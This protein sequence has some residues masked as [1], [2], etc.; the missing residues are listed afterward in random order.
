[1]S[2]F[3]LVARAVFLAS[4]LVGVGIHEG[5]H[6]AVLRYYGYRHRYHFGLDDDEEGLVARVRG[7][8]ARVEWWPFEERARGVEMTLASVAPFPICLAS[9]AT[10]ELG[11]LPELANYALAGVVFTTVPSPQDVKVAV[12]G[13]RWWD[14]YLAGALEAVANHESAEGFDQVF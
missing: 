9:L 5:A 14:D 4:A 7:M 13:L 2:D 6:G 12:M 11:V 8:G 10:F 3:S 1:M